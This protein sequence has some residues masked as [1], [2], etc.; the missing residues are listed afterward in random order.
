MWEIWAFL[1]GQKVVFLKDHDGKVTKTVA[2][3]TPFGYVAKRQWPFSFSNATLLDDGT[4]Y[5][6][7][8][9]FK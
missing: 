8:W 6:R 2:Y 3:K 5:V 7:S 4:V 1:T 9:K